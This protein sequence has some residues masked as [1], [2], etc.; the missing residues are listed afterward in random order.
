LIKISPFDARRLV[1]KRAAV[2][3]KIP[4]I[5]PK[6]DKTLEARDQVKRVKPPGR[7]KLLQNGKCISGVGTNGRLPSAPDDHHDYLKIYENIIFT[8]PTVKSRHRSDGA[9]Q[10]T[11]K[12]TAAFEKL[13]KSEVY[14]SMR[15]LG[16]QFQYPVH[17][18]LGFMFK[19][20]NSSLWPVS[21][22]D[23]DLSNLVKAIEDAINAVAYRDDRLIVTLE[24]AKMCGPCDAIFIRIQSAQRNTLVDRIRGAIA[25][26]SGQTA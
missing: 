16:P 24:T 7:V 4:D 8:K 12:K 20:A 3:I 10:H 1:Q 2:N 23:G 17:V 11:P 15:M 9:H 22:T 25:Q 6:K 5:N 13:I 18:T 26:A 14:F 21:Q 19:S